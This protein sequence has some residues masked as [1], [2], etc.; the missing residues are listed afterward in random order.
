MTAKLTLIGRSPWFA[1][2]PSSPALSPKNQAF[3]TIEHAGQGPLA[4]VY[5]SL[6]GSA[7]TPADAFV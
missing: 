4:D 2:E 5:L 6:T 7:G 3:A 1:R